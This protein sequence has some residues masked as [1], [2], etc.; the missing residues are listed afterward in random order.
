MQLLKYV[1]TLCSQIDGIVVLEGAIPELRTIAAELTV[2][3]GAVYE[4]AV[5]PVRMYSI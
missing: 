5:Y 4:L 3:E 1:N 2:D